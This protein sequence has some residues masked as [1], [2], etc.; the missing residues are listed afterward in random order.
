MKKI[1]TLGSKQFLTGVSIAGAHMDNGGIFYKADGVTPLF[2]AGASQSANNG[3]LTA[4]A[5]GTV[6]SGTLTGNIIAS[7]P[8]GGVY[9]TAGGAVFAT[10]DNNIWKLAFSS[11]LPSGAIGSVHSTTPQLT[12]GLVSFFGKLYYR[13]VSQIGQYDPGG[14]TYTDAWKGSGD[15][16]STEYFGTMY[17]YLDQILFGNGYGKLG[18]ISSAL[19]LTASALDF[20]TQSQVSAISD[21]GT[22]AVIAITRNSF[23][24]STNLVASRILF[25]DG[26]SSSWLRDYPVSDP[27]IYC[28]R[29]TPIGLFAFGA[30]GIW[31]VTFD[32]LKKVFS[33]S[34][35]LYT[36]TATS[37]IRYGT[38]ASFFS[39]AVVWGGVSGSN[40][41]LKS[42]GK[43]DGGAPNSFLTP[44]K[45]TGS[46]NITDV[47]GQLL[48]GYVFVADS[49]PQLMYYPIGSGTQQTSVS[50][51]TIYFP[52][53]DKY[54]IEK[55]NVVFGEPLASGDSMSI[56]LK[57][58]EDTGVIETTPAHLTATYA[59]DGAIRR[60]AMRVKGFTADEQLS[61]TI[62]FTAGAV[63]IKRIEVFG[64]P[65][66]DAD[67]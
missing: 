49:T 41:A 51:Q 25:W 13:Q 7:I 9:Y 3:L 57:S 22:Y 10:S 47:N 61:L 54:T 21:D 66:P 34:P 24:D 65:I 50:A 44:I 60:K 18:S 15:G 45:L 55:I 16:V 19:V 31:Q 53:G 40:N 27:C 35:G 2:D 23:G 59:N 29:K 46:K 6:V 37:G 48:K 64:S 28:L 39:E 56:Q 8:D 4:G 67:I 17:Q 12:Q 42:L 26:Y 20:E 62:N 1:L 32:G 33:V 30:T 11:G 63:K 36:V 43:L 5:G 58:D 52:L 38:A 14:P